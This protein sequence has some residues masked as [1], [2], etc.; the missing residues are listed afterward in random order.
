MLKSVKFVNWRSLRDVTVELGP[1]TVLVG[2]NSAGKTNIV[3]GLK[4]Q[5]DSHTDGILD[6]VMRLT[7]DRIAHIE[8]KQ[9][10]V[11]ARPSAQIVEI[12]LT[13][14]L[15][16]VSNEDVE[17][18]LRLR[19]D[20]AKL[21]RFDYGV[22]ISEGGQLL[23]DSGFESMPPFDIAG[24]AINIANPPQYRRSREIK[25]QLARYYMRRWQILSENFS[26]EMEMSGKAGGDRYVVE[27]DGRNVPLLLELMQSSY[28][29]VYANFVDDVHFVLGH[30]SELSVRRQRENLDLRVFVVEREL[31]RSSPTI[32]AG[33]SRAIAMLVSL[34][35]LDMP[36]KVEPSSFPPRDDGTI[37]PSFPGLVI[38]EEPDT[39]LNPGVLDRLVEVLRRITEGPNPRQIIMTTHNPT[40]LSYFAPEEVRVVER[41][42]NGDTQVYPIRADT[43]EGLESIKT[44]GDVWLTRALG[45]IAE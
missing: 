29:D 18:R 12:A 17:D 11:L 21:P 27:S 7:A 38:V 20:P 23:D 15:P 22:S 31:G 2:A 14:S 3:D 24:K 9:T 28:P 37:P 30:V 6:S 39:A 44:L 1:I 32:S 36:Q 26:A 16:Q 19:F 5:R 33:T 40:F 4:F 45:G 10:T 43:L 13:V 8:P 41:D 34:H 42:E 25:E 35:A